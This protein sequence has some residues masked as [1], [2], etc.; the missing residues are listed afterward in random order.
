[1]EEEE[2]VEEGGEKEE[3]EKTKENTAGS[4]SSLSRPPRSL[5]RRSKTKKTKQ[6]RS[7]KRKKT[8]PFADGDAALQNARKLAQTLEH[9]AKSRAARSKSKRVSKRDRA[10]GPLP[11]DDDE[12]WLFPAFQPLP[13]TL[14]PP[15]NWSALSACKPAGR[16]PTRARERRT[17][18]DE[19]VEKEKEE[20]EN[21]ASRTRRD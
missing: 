9:V 5:S 1:M 4:A 11:G 18:L 16:F 3:E 12:G 17:Y 20:E 6:K 19:R 21:G 2:E 10:R 14:V 15:S 13:A 8:P 7:R